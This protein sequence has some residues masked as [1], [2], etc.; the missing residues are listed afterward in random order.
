MITPVSS[1][2]PN[3]AAFLAIDWAD[4]THAFSLCPD[5]SAQVE[6]G[7]VQ[8]TPQALQ[9]WLADLGR[10]F[11][12]QPIAVAV[13]LTRGPLIWALLEHPFLTIYPVTPITSAKL[14]QAFYPSGSKSDPADSHLLLDILLHHRPHL[15]L[16]RLDET[17]T[18][19]L[20]QLCDDRRQAVQHRTACVQHLTAALKEYFPLALV[21][22]GKLTNDMACHF[23]DKWTSLEELQAA[24][25]HALRKF[26]YGHNS[27]A[28]L[29]PRLQQIKEAHPLTRD[30]A[31]IE[32]GRR[33]VRLLA[34]MILL[35]N[36][37]IGQYEDRITQLF[38]DHPDRALFESLP[39]AGAALAPRLLTAFGV[40]RARFAAAENLAKYSG[41]APIQR[42][43]GKTQLCFKRWAFPRFLHQTFFEYAGKSVVASV[44]AKAYYQ[45][46]RAK[47]RAHNAILRSLA[48]KWI[49]ILW[50]CWR[51]NQPYNEERY[52]A[53][54]KKA[55]S[56]YA[57][58]T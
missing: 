9:Q 52:L 38:G 20:A 10:R 4:Q 6:S 30:P 21:V 51:A 8:H 42:S 12:G 34:Q 57:P 37:H 56:P 31:V 46:Q 28:D 32:A 13:E 27:R 48:F 43:S 39:G 14:R 26:L 53:V 11:G 44:W 16:L 3:F 35:L 41:I 17:Q 55:G 18:R 54:L 47:G 15:R 45:A 24:K 19:L 25:P 7:T 58:Q 33:Q 50:S 5:G 49:R 23:L 22:A 1:A 36:E 2:S 40:D 29:E